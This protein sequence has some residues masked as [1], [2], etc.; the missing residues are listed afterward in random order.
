MYNI[1]VSIYLYIMYYTQHNKYIYAHTHTHTHTHTNTHT[2]THKYEIK[3][4]ESARGYCS[5]LP[6]TSA[7][8]LVYEALSY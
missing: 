2:H 4:M 5:R 7:H 1:Y 3:N 8:L 6:Q